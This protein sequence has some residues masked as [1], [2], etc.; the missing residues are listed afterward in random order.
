MVGV[1]VVPED[2][3]AIVAMVVV[4]VGCAFVVVV[5]VT[6]LIVGRCVCGRF[7][8][9]MNICLIKSQSR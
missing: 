9:G 2:V 3:I 8:C 4:D 1:L 5:D 7:I 6:E